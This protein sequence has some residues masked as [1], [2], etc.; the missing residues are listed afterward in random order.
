MEIP[1][2]YAW[3]TYP[4]LEAWDAGFSTP[5]LV[6]KKIYSYVY[7]QFF[8]EPGLCFDPARYQDH[9]KIKAKQRSLLLNSNGS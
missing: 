2:F 9:K 5:V 7:A 4:N 6:Y 1:S 3:A 8:A